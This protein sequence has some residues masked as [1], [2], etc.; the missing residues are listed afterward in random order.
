[1]EYLVD[2]TSD[3]TQVDIDAYVSEH[4]LT[5]LRHYDKLEK[6]YLVSASAM[7]P[8]TAIVE[9]VVDNHQNGITLLNATQTIDNTADTDSFDITSDDQ[10][11][12]VATFNNIDY[13][14]ST[15]TYSVRGKK[16]VIYL[17]DSGVELTH[18]EFEGADIVNLFSFN[19]DFTPTNPHGTS[20]A[21]IMVGKTCG[22]TAATVKS[23]KIFDQNQPTL[24]SD[25]LAAFNAVITDYLDNGQKSSFVNLSWNIP[26]NVYVEDK[27]N[28][29]INYGLLVV[30]AAGN[31]G[32]PIGDITPASM[33]NVIVVG[34][35]D[36]NLMPCDFS[37]Y[38]ASSDISVTG[39]EVNTGTLTGWAPGVLIRTALLNSSYGYGYGTSC[40]AAITTAALVYNFD[41]YVSDTGDI[42]YATLPKAVSTVTFRR[43]NMLTLSEKYSAAKNRIATILADHIPTALDSASAA[44]EVIIIMDY[45]KN[46]SRALFNAYVYDTVTYDALPPGLAINN[47]FIAGVVANPENKNY[48]QH[49]VN[50]TVSGPGV[51]P[52]SFI[53]TITI[54]KD[55]AY[56]VENDVPVSSLDDQ[57]IVALASCY[58]NGSACLDYGSCNGNCQTSSCA[59]GSCLGSKTSCACYCFG[60]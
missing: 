41:L 34:A 22:I 46:F 58:W 3:A 56:L 55:R 21:S 27:I 18:P 5:V 4:N 16:S 11:W 30:A 45:D 2:F 53:V 39:G 42:F 47:G 35:Y 52:V 29:L 7:P 48:E 15:Y 12:K 24:L 23:V 50:M 17:L 19:N 33:S 31:S 14:Q 49:V 8:K 54:A 44:S 10:W 1:M 9:F 37:N 40:S 32:Q 26:K 57:L 51:D 60:C 13:S 59:Y 36:Q 38:S 43:D 6:V 20:L 28:T 25:M